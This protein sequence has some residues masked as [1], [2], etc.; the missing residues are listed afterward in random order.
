MRPSLKQPVSDF[1]RKLK[2]LIFFRILFTTLL[3]GSTIVLHIGESPSPLAPPLLILYCVIIG[4]YLLSIIYTLLLVRIRW[5]R[6]LAYCQIGIDTFVITLIIYVT[7][8][9]SSIFSFLY[10]IVI[11]YA[12]ILLLRR[13]A[14]IIAMLCSLQYTLLI[15]LEY[16]R[17]LYPLSAD[18]GWADLSGDWAHVLYK[19]MVTAIACFAVAFLSSFLAEQHSRTKNELRS[20]EDQVKRVEKLA[21]VG[22][23]AAGLAHE[24]KNPLASLIGSIQILKDDMRYDPDH[25]KLM[26]IAM[27]EADRLSS[28]LT[29]FLMFAKPPTGKS[30]PLVLDQFITDGL[31]LFENDRGLTT[32]INLISTLIPGIWI[33]MDPTHLR[34]I[35]WN[36]LL[37]AAEAIDGSGTIEVAMKPSEDDSVRVQI[38]D[39][40]CGIAPDT[41]DSIFDPFF[42]TKPNGTGLGLSIIHNILESYGARMNVR[43]HINQG[44]TFTLNFKQ[45]GPP[46]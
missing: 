23:M 7:G 26:Q 12:S 3:L 39:T 13:G 35:L 31:K 4:V 29:N 36:L 27:R 46:T 37:N 28:L 40:G 18:F 8:S 44:T 17:L 33:E 20:M 38:S 25:E 9:F 2:W 14:M 6:V 21:A 1:D 10:L 15:S 16:L 5:K 41:I 45:I 22:E 24:I 43:S 11:V 42:T 19:T 32:R 30:E 34:Q